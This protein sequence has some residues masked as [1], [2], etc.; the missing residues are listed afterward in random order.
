M[1]PNGF[2]RA[3]S[4]AHHDN[5]DKHRPQKYSGK[6]YRSGENK[7]YFLGKGQEKPTF[8]KSRSSKA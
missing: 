2:S 3:Y 1:A 7:Q 5:Y 8:P 6:Y 4:N